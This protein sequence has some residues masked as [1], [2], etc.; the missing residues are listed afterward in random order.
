MHRC[1]AFQSESVALALEILDGW[2]FEG[3]VIKV[4]KAKF[5]LK[6]EYDPSKKKKRLTAAQKKRF[7]ESQERSKLNFFIQ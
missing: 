7:L 6:G 4:E 5:E 2:N 3:K 1:A